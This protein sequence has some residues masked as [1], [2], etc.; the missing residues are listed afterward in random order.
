MFIA[1][2]RL[3]FRDVDAWHKTEHD[4]SMFALVG[5]TGLNPDDADLTFTSSDHPRRHSL[6]PKSGPR[7][8][9]PGYLVR[10]EGNKMDN[11]WYALGDTCVDRLKT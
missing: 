11:Q 2:V 7:M 8:A 4:E 5:I 9:Y 6:L 1:S 3:T 10:P